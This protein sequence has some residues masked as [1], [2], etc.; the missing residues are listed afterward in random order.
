MMDNYQLDQVIT[1]AVDD[2]QTEVGLD[3][4]LWGRKTFSYYH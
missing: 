3:M 1:Q 4:I 2:M